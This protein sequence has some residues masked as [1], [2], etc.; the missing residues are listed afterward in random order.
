M[1]KILALILT[2]CMVLALAACG[3]TTAPTATQAPATEA[4]ATEAPATEAPATEAPATEA[5]A[6]EAP[7][8]EAPVEA[9]EAP[10]E[11]PAA[12][13]GNTIAF[14]T[15]AELPTEPEFDPNPDYD[16][17]TVV[18]YT[19]E[20]IQ[21]DLVCTVSAKKDLSE[22]YLEC[23]FYGDDQMTLTTVENGEYVNHADKTGFMAG[24]TPAILDIAKE[25][26]LWVSLHDDA[27][28]APAETEEEP[29]AEEGNAMAFVTEAELPTEPEFDPNPDY[30]MYTVVE[31]TIEDIQADLVCTVS[32]KADLS[33]FFLECNFYGDD[34]M[35]LTTVED[36]EYVNHA[37]KT[38]F[39]A[40]DTPAILDIAKEQNLWVSLH[41]D[42]VEAAGEAVEEPADAAALEPMS[43]ADYAA[44]AVDDPVC[45]I[46]YAQAHQSWWDG[47]VTVYAADEDGAYFLYNMACS[48]EDA[49][50]L[51][52]GAK[53]QVTGYKG[54]W[55][56]EVEIVDATFEFVDG[57]PYVA[58]PVDV[59][60]QLGTDALVDYQNRLVAL[61]GLT[62][63]AY[64][65]N[66]AAFQYKDPDGKTDDL[67]FKV[68]KDGKTFEFCVEY[69]LCGND[70]PVYQAVEAL[71][72]GQVVDLEGFLYWYEGANL[73]TTSLT[74][75][76]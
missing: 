19:I 26:N 31:Y 57:D 30:D 42:E 66:G 33:E 20:D 56:G 43:Y 67:Y 49:A 65:E 41:D 8:T 4:P 34:Q 35:T 60:E 58:E 71:E 11:E 15:E 63:E 53:I 39:M 36:G 17:Y 16:M 40:G 13:E 6:T 64:D 68:S 55:A 72:V 48:E 18:E 25:Q 46:C 21:A 70:T 14:V 28:K 47:K 50:K 52:D 2:L 38:G 69:Y 1:K 62:V 27:A 75:V 59:T 22:F 44:A 51:T 7:A 76:E 10:V 3:S 61:K 73:H 45:V 29:A 37:D 23:N 12:E 32:A 74:V 9:T 54:E 24:D 5:P